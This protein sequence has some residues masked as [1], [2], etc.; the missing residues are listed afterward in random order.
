MSLFNY[1]GST[2]DAYKFNT[3]ELKSITDFGET[4]TTSPW[5]TLPSGDLFK[6]YFPDGNL[7]NI[8][9]NTTEKVEKKEKKKQ[10]GNATPTAYKNPLR[11]IANGG[12]LQYPIDLDTDLQDYFEIQIF[13]YRPARSLPGIKKTNQGYNK[14]NG[15]YTDTTKEGDAGYG[16]YFSGSNRRGNRQNFRLQDLQSTIQLPIPPSIKD[17]NAV[18][19]AGGTMSGLA[20]SVFGPTVN[21]FLGGDKAKEFQDAADKRQTG[22]LRNFGSSILNALSGTGGVINSTFSNLLSAV[23]NK[24]FRRVTSL[25]AIAQAVAGLGVQIDVDQAITRTSGAVRNPNLELLFK[26]PS[27]RNF[28]FTIRFTPRD[29]DESKRVRMIIRALK[30]HSAVK[31]NPRVFNNNTSELGSNFLLGTPDVF[32]L[33]YIKA[34]T[35]KDIKGLNKFKTCALNSISV[36]YTGEIGRFAAYEEDSQPVTT[37]I[38]LSFTELTPIYDVDYTEFTTDDDV[39]L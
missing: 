8:N 26:G 16:G 6:D 33:R 37:I 36:D 38:S 23:E 27:L 31:R 14:E 32:K 4:F 10:S 22:A 18:D 25:N 30:Q 20:A 39:G 19:F 17:M 9:A 28:N 2:P 24:E 29:A 12:V 5:T 3:D 35:Q 7:F 21:A 15:K 11:K 13:N 1:D 34:R